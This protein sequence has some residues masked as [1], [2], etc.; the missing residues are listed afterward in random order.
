[1]ID[2]QAIKN[3]ILGLA[4]QGKL[5][6]QRPEDGTAEDLL[7]KIRAEKK[8]LIAE[9]KIKREKALSPITEDEKPFDIPE[10]WCWVRLG[11]IGNYK[12]GPFGSSLTKSIFV[13]DG[14]ASIKVYEQKN[15]IKKDWQLG[16]YFI[17]KEYYDERMKGFT[18]TPG[19]IIVS[20]AGTIGETYILPKE[21]RI[22][23]INQALMRI[24]VFSSINKDFYLTCFNHIIKNMAQLQSQGTALKNIPPF[25][26]LKNM[27]IPLPPLAEQERIVEKLEQAFSVLD[28]IDELQA[29]YEK[30]QEV[31]KNKLL[32]LAIQGKLT[33]QRPEDGTAAELLEKVR[34]EKERLIAEGK[35]KRE[36]ALPPISDEEIPFDIPDNWCWV[37]LN[38]IFEVINGDRGKNY[39][40][41]Y[42]LSNKGNIPFIS[43]LN[44]DG[45][46][47]SND[48]KL[49]Y[50]SEEQYQKLRAG[51]LVKNDTV[52]CIRGSLG[53]HG[54]FPFEKGAIA[55]SL[56]I[57]RGYICTLTLKDYLMTYLDS[58]LFFDEIKKYNNGTAQ[59]NLAAKSLEQFLIPLPPLAEQERIVERLNELLPLCER[60]KK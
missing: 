24:S 32:E 12:K 40:A 44:L 30:N 38:S 21:C 19:D 2:T 34:A 23:I 59:P 13:S 7:E 14:K 8:R 54:N 5:T 51:K 28:T 15:A 49:L 9:G 37:R 6:E 16:E 36:K 29:E 18:V 3:K 11:E 43:A 41:K 26:I 48:E 57:V 20:C 31:L 53:K 25:S 45:R 22:G 55:S 56:V 27:I 60:M 1:M 17:T 39:P 50:M 58:Q 47:V 52:I 4:I 10:N 33:D 42:L 35:I 46:T